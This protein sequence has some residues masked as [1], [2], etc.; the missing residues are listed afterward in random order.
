MAVVNMTTADKHPV[1]A[2]RE[3]PEYMRQIDSGRT[4]H[5]DLRR[6]LKAGNPAQIRSPVAAP[7]AYHP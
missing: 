4:H 1:H 3:C 7:I 2:I 6:V 5:P